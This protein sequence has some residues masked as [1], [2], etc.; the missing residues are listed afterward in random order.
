M[1]HPRIVK[2]DFIV[3][4]PDGR[5]LLSFI[6]GVLTVHDLTLVRTLTAGAASVVTFGG[7]PTEDPEAEGAL[8][9]GEGGVVM[10][11]H[12]A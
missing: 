12:P 6:G 3:K 7:L 4:A 11:S 10:V 8:Y 1:A 2:G 5:D 9:E